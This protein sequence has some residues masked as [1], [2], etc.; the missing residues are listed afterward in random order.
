MGVL[1]TH[2]VANGAAVPPGGAASAAPPA[3]AHGLHTA[4]NAS[5]AAVAPKVLAESASLTADKQLPK[6]MEKFFAEVGRD[7]ERRMVRYLNTNQLAKSLLKKCEI[8][9]NNNP[10]NGW[11]YP[12]GT[13]A[14]HAPLEVESMDAVWS[15]VEQEDFT[16]QF[17]IAKGTSRR[18]AMQSIHYQC[19]GFLTDL[20]HEVVANHARELRSMVSKEEFVKAC[21]EFKTSN[22]GGVADDLDAPIRKPLDSQLARM[23]LGR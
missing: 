10:E 6:E 12:N 16:C 8:Y 18:D 23:P 17:T 21:G 11:Q 15:K 5:S 1:S 2:H 14:W 9:K 3:G 20:H 13:R 4:A 7:F 22:E 19:H